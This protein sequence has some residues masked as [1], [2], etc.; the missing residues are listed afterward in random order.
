MVYALGIFSMIAY[1]VARIHI[2]SPNMAGEVFK[3]LVNGLLQFL[4]GPLYLQ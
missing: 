1:D 2:Q 3:Y 4:H